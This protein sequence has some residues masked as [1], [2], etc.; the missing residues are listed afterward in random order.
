MSTI[1]TRRDFLARAARASVIL[2]LPDLLAPGSRPL[3]G[4][5][6]FD[7][8][9]ARMAR[10]KMP[11]VVIRIPKDPAWRLELG[12]RLV[13]IVDGPTRRDQPRFGVSPDL[14]D[15]DY[16]LHELLLEAVF[17]CVEE[18]RIA[19][20][21]RRP[22]AND[23]L[24][25]I[26]S[27]GKRI[28][29]AAL[30]DASL[31]R[32]DS[33]EAEVRRL[34]HGAKNERLRERAE[35][36]QRSVRPDSLRLFNPFLMSS[37]LRPRFA[38]RFRACG[39]VVRESAC[40]ARTSG[41]PSK[42]L[43]ALRWRLVELADPQLFGAAAEAV[44]SEGRAHIPLFVLWRIESPSPERAARL[45]CLLETLYLLAA[46]SDESHL[47]P[48]G[49]VVRGDR[50]FATGCGRAGLGNSGPCGTGYIGPMTR[51]F[52]KFVAD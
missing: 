50:D 20:L 47:L 11:G 41:N 22:N 49:L 9:L 1:E 44:V 19:H 24:I 51:E 12:K 7:D 46:E 10:E 6:A 23:T 15:A 38:E 21:L 8:A 42:E 33:L 34:V 16:S 25:L 29:G 31:A 28:D 5:P 30:D 13:Y 37:P 18:R 32:A 26:D 36:C 52:V 14:T 43:L 17:V 3:V 4:N 2:G 48:F 39:H 27:Q 35:E 40:E 45:R